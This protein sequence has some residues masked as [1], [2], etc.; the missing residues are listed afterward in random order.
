MLSSQSEDPEDS[1]FSGIQ[2]IIVERNISSKSIGLGSPSKSNLLDIVKEEEPPVESSKPTASRKERVDQTPISKKHAK[3]PRM[4]S[5]LNLASASRVA[6]YG[7]IMKKRGT[8]NK[9][10]PQSAG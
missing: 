6:R 10:G 5:K 1:N 3:E 8:I 4:R 9:S 2:Q 7:S